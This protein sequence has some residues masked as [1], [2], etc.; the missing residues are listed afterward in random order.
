MK[1][2]KAFVEAIHQC[3]PRLVYS[4]SFPERLKEKELILPRLSGLPLTPWTYYERIPTVHCLN[5]LLCFRGTVVRTGGLKLQEYSKEWECSKCKT[6]HFTFVDDHQY[7][8]IPKPLFC[9]GAID[10]STCKNVKFQEIRD[11]EVPSTYYDYQEIKVQELTSVLSIGAVPRSILVILRH[12]LVD[13]CRA[14]DDVIIT[15]VY[16]SR[17]KANP[18]SGH[19][20]MVGDFFI[21][22]TS[23]QSAT[24]SID[25]NSFAMEE[26]QLKEE[27]EKHWNE[28]AGDEITSKR[29]LIVNSFCPHIHGMFLVKLATLMTVIGG[30]DMRNIE[31][32]EN[33]PF[34]E[35]TGVRTNRRE[36]HLLL[37]GDPGKQ[38]C[39]DAFGF[40]PFVGTGKSQ[41]LVQAAKLINR[42]VI[43]TGSGTTSAGLTCSAVKDGSDW[44]LEAGAL[45]MADRGLCCI[46]EFTALKPHDRTAIH[47]AMEQQTLSVANVN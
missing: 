15:G 41:F 46:D 11:Q 26:A 39:F 36:G 14:G 38:M 7:G 1:Y 35:S 42:S 10:G 16:C 17:F 24:S 13:Q 43:T 4:H 2:L 31:D 29:S 34:E 5:K 6:R 47:E 30:S 18:K 45:V 28:P 32:C 19:T 40:I 25:S 9:T 3:Q 33:E 27:Y 21:Q 37:V 12:D 22:A 23:I 8:I 20:R 44:Q